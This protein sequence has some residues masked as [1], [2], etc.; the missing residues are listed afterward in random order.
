MIKSEKTDSRI[1]AGDI[2]NVVNP[3]EVKR[4]GYVTIESG[5]LTANNLKGKVLAAESYVSIIKE[6]D[7]TE[8]I[9]KHIIARPEK[10]GVDRVQTNLQGALVKNR[11]YLANTTPGEIGT[12]GNRFTG[13]KTI[14]TIEGD[15]Y[16][17]K[18]QEPTVV[19]K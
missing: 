5:E 10:T 18:P 4:M 16:Q 14:L 6:S 17:K 15:L 13:I 12:K 2:S 8:I 3:E 11:L 7:N 1:T 19:H 9:Y